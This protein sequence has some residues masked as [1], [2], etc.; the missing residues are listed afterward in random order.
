MKLPD[1]HLEQTRHVVIVF[2]GRKD[3]IIAQVDKD[4]FLL[5]FGAA[6]RFAEQTL[7]GER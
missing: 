7:H 5:D 3:E 4:L 1:P 6:S 2:T